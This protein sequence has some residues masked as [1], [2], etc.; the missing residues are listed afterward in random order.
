MPDFPMLLIVIIVLALVFD[1]INGF[2]DAANAIATIV[3]TKVLTPFQAV[4]WAAMFNFAAYFIFKDHGVGETIAKTVN[5]TIG[6]E[7]ILAGIVAAIIWNLITWWYGIPS[8]SSHTLIGGFTGAAVAAAGSFSVINTP[9]MLKIIAFIVIAPLTGLITAFIISI[10]F[11]NSFRKGILPKIVGL[12][13]IA[14]TCFLLYQVIETDPSKLKTHYDAYFLKVIFYSNNF[15]WILIGFILIALSIFSLFLSSLNYAQSE[16][17]FKKMQLVSSAAVSI[18]HGGNDAQKVMG[19]ITVA[20]I[21]GGQIAKF[22]QMPTWVPLACYTAIA[23][24]TMSGG[25]KIIKTMGTRITKV[26]P[27]E[28]V[29][30]ESAGAITLFITEMLKIPVS[31]THVITG[32]IIGVGATKRLSAVRW[33]VTVNLLWAWILTIPVSAILATLIYYLIHFCRQ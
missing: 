23:L 29:A 5:G 30:A 32:S 3:S 16:R 7:V 2:H 18:G 9:V 24:G 21:S 28:G 13:V 14:A 1:F 20:L 15:K 19:I 6:L 22:N 33:G 8:S 25:W 10:W 11:L 12:L 31:T 26:T 27:F 17:W 4:M